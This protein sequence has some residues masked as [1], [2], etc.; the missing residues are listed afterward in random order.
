[1]AVGVL[2]LQGDVRE[3]IQLVEALGRQAD[4]VKTKEA[5]LLSDA[6]IIPGGESTTMSKL[7]IAFELLDA[8]RAFVREKPTLG[9]CA[10]LILLSEEVEGALPDQ[11]LI[12]GLPIKVSRNAYGGQTH[13]FEA[14]VKVMNQTERVAFIRAPKIL[15]SG[16]TEVIATYGSEV[17]GVRYRKALG[18]TFHPEITGAKA[19]HSLLLSTTYP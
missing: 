7:L 3:H 6:L 13:S 14:D 9:T 1:L 15:D 10:G 19:L 12:G 4:A 17:I 11:Q 8:V 5:L 16:S 2:A 18:A